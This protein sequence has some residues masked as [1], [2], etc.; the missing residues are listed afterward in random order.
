MVLKIVGIEDSLTECTQY[1]W[2]GVDIEFDTE[3][4]DRTVEMW[5]TLGDMSYL[6]ELKKPFFK[7]C[8][9][10]FV[11]RGFVG[12]RIIRIGCRRSFLDLKN[13]KEIAKLLSV[14]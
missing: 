11:I 12:D 8:T 5:R 14:D 6:K 2:Y 7:I 1:D 9:D 3:L 4:T 13:R 10:N